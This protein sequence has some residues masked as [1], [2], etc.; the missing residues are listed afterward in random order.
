[1]N[2]LTVPQLSIGCDYYDRA[3]MVPANGRS[4]FPTEQWVDG[5]LG[6]THAETIGEQRTAITARY[7]SLAGTS[8]CGCVNL[9]SNDPL[10]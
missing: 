2:K 9:A 3:I 1:M 8:P 5:V 7:F 10:N 6:V 4:V